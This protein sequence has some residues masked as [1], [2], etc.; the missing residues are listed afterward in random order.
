MEYLPV[1][2]TKVRLQGATPKVPMKLIATIKKAVA[3][4]NQVVHGKSPKISSAT[5]HEILEAIHDC[6]YLF[7]CYNGH[8][9]AWTLISIETQ[10]LMVQESTGKVDTSEQ[11]SSKRAK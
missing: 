7:D 4:R 5:L 3:L 9:W 6:L 8:R 10:R 2:P 1:L 11:K